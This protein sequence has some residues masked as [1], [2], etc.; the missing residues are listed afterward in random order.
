MRRSLPT[1]FLAIFAVAALSACGDSP[2]GT[3]D[4]GGD[5]SADTPSVDVAVD[6]GE[7]TDTASD[8]IEGDEQIEPDVSADVPDTA[9]DVG[10]DTEED[11]DE[12]VE[13]SCADDQCDIDGA[14]FDS[15]DVNPDNPCELCLVVVSTDGWSYQ[16]D[17]ACDDGDLCTGE[18]T[19]FEGTCMG[20]FFVCDDGN[21]CT[22]DVCDADTGECSSAPIPEDGLCFDDDPCSL[23]DT[24][25]DGVCVAGGDTLHCES[26]NPCMAARCEPGVGCVTEPLDGIACNDGDVCTT[27]G[28]CQEGTCVDSEPIDCDDGNLCTLNWCDPD[29][30]CAS[31]SIADLCADDNPCTDAA[32]DPALGC[33]YP[34]NTDPC[35]DGLTCTTFDICTEGA[36]RG[37][38][39]E[40]D[41][42][43]VCTDDRC[44]EPVGVTNLP[45]D[46]VCDDNDACT[47]GDVCA[48]GGCVPGTEPLNC[49][50]GNVC[51]DE[52]CD[53][54]TGCGYVN[55]TAACDDGNVCTVEDTCGD[56][57]CVSGAPLDCDDGNACTIDTCGPVDGCSNTL[58]VSNACR[59]VIT[60]TYP[61]RAATILDEGTGTITVTGTVESGAGTIDTFTINGTDVVVGAGGAF[62]LEVEP[63]NGGNFLVIEAEDAMGSPRK[64]V[65]SYAFSQSYVLPNPEAGTGYSEEGLG[66]YISDVALASVSEVLVAVLQGFDLAALLPENPMFD[67]AGVEVNIREDVA[68]PITFGTPV[69]TLDSTPEGLELD[70]VIPNLV[71]RLNIDAWTCGGNRNYAATSLSVS[72]VVAL[73]VEDHALT[74]ALNN[75]NATLSGGGFSPGCW[76]LSLASSFIAG[77]LESTIED[78]LNEQIGDSLTDALSGLALD[79]DFDFPSIDPEGAPVVIALSSDFNAVT[80]DD[81]GLNLELR[82]IVSSDTVVPYT[83]L[84]IPERNG[85]GTPPQQLEFFEEDA[86][87]VLLA[88]DTVSQLLWGAWN[89]G[90]L[91]FDV[92]ESLLGDLDLSA[93]GITDLELSASG[94]LQPIASDCGADSLI[95]HIGDLRIDA[96]MSLL[97][98]PLEVILYLSLGAAFDVSAADGEIAFAITDIERVEMQVEVTDEAFISVESTFEGLILDNLVPAL[99][100]SLGGDSLGSFA[101]PEIDI[102]G[103]ID[104]AT[105]AVEIVPSQVRRNEGNTVVGGSL[106]VTP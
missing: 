95:A 51:T 98:T 97:G 58:I 76:L 32:C 35:D 40:V 25:T 41:D 59:P 87:E 49:D 84:G 102:S 57:A 38:A 82:T 67:E 7:D 96:S 64:V 39:V 2:S 26:D 45:N 100:D 88:D 55:N 54:E 1:R 94:M 53:S 47:V 61:P 15:G 23:N 56:G 92:P 46:D 18:D 24:C 106:E 99:L 75:V 83:N 91:E 30:G 86:F 11:T 90:F 63:D 27:P 79:F 78:S 81:D 4:T 8:V 101:L 43:N 19:C 44:V 69:V 50:D 48:E 62:S 5:T 20:T 17:V 89:G 29:V 72:A 42:S 68:E 13:P 16:D 104:G 80:S 85:C 14:C 74:G 9:A 103:L 71:V 31:R 3:G 12:D 22:D 65:Q 66:L 34:F 28:I 73:G 105:G 36:C 33:V 93:Y 37:V 6:V 21:A 52:A 70:V 60:V 77:E 10:E